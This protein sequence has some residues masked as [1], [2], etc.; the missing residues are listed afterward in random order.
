MQAPSGPRARRRTLLPPPGSVEDA[1]TET[2]TKPGS[3]S[4]QSRA[5][6]RSS[7]PGPSMTFQLRQQSPQREQVKWASGGYANSVVTGRILARS[8]K[9]GTG[10]KGPGTGYW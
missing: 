9:E 6:S 10:R 8:G 7:S 3:A 2:S 1:A 4:D 5:A